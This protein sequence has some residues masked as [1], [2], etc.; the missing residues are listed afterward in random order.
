M[1][2]H[3]VAIRPA[4]PDDA[5]RVW[6]TLE[7]TIR[8]G[9]TTSLARDLSRGDALAFWFGASHEVFVA[10]QAGAI[11]GTYFLRANQTGAGGHV[12]NSLYVVSPSATGRGIAQVMCDHSLEQARTRGFLAMQF[13][14]EPVSNERRV[15][16][17]ERAG[18]QIVGRLPKAFRHP[19]LGLIDALV[20]FRSL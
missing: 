20:M 17:W 14:L 18:F 19:E 8:A 15:K 6:Q 10:E 4:T 12:A 1:T 13:N 5:E 16:L 11:V 3:E 2:T 7:P 9:E